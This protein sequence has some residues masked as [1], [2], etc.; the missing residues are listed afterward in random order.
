MKISLNGSLSPWRGKFEK[1]SV[2]GCYRQNG[3]RNQLYL[4][5]HAKQQIVQ[6]IQAIHRQ[7]RLQGR[8]LADHCR[9][10]DRL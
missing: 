10:G 1:C 3:E 8:C 2:P 5:N 9:D 6:R 4:R 7:I